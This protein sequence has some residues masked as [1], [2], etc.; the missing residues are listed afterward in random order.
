LEA[1]TV[2]WN[3]LEVTKNTVETVES[4]VVWRQEEKELEQA[5]QSSALPT[6]LPS[7]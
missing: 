6:E 4:E 3:V 7:C 5:F 1:E 2:F